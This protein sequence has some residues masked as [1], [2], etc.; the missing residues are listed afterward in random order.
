MET[1]EPGMER[2]SFL[3][4]SLFRIMHVIRNRGERKSPLKPLFDL[5]FCFGLP[6][7]GLFRLDNIL[8]LCTYFCGLIK[9]ANRFQHFDVGVCLLCLLIDLQKN[10]RRMNTTAAHTLD[11]ITKRYPLHG[12]RLFGELH[13]K[14]HRYRN[15]ELSQ[16]LLQFPSPAQPHNT[17]S[18]STKNCDG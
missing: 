9:T 11:E 4:I 14:T 16:T 1:K 2:R 6:M 13:L 3:Q 5:L 10:R 17:I 18:S 12:T 7:A 8:F 15:L